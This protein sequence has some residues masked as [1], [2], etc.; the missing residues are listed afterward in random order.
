VATTK[1][2]ELGQ[3]GS[4]VNVHNENI[5]LD[6]NVHGQYAGFDSD[7]DIAIAGKTTSNL[8][9]GSNLYYTDAR[10]DARVAL[11]VDSAPS[12]LNTL[13]ELAAALGDDANFSTTVTN[14]IAAK[15]P[16]AGG[17]ITGNVT[18]GDNNKAIFGAEL[19]I[20]SDATHARIREY[21]SGQ[22]KIQ[23]D[24][25]QLLTSNGASTYLEGNASTSAVTLYHASNSPRL[26]TTSTGINVTGSGVPNITLTS[27]SGPYSYIESNTVGSLGFAADEGNTG[28]ATNINFRVDGN[29]IARLTGGAFVVNDGSRDIDFRVESDDNS[30]MLFVDAG[31]NEVGIGTNDP[32][33]PL[34]VQTSHSSTDV[35]AAN[36]NSTLSIGNSATGNGVYNAIKFAANQQD[37]YIMSFNNAQ[38]ADRRLGFFLGSTAGDAVA[39]ERLSIRGNGNVGIGTTSPAETL[40]VGT[41]NFRIDTDTNSTF[42][43]ADAGT[44]AIALY[45]GTGDELYMGANN[46]YSLRFKTD[47]NI[48]MD[49][50]GS[51]GIG[52]ASPEQNLHIKR[53]SGSDTGGQ[54]HIL[55]D[56]ADDSGP[57]YALRIGDTA[58][59]GDF[60]IDRRHGSTWSSSLSI[61]RATGNVG[62]NNTAPNATLAIANNNVSHTTLTVTP[63]GSGDQPVAE[64]ARGSGSHKG[65][66]LRIAGNNY[67]NGSNANSAFLEIAA[68]SYS[69]SGTNYIKAYDNTGTDFV[70]RGDGNVGIGTSSPNSMLEVTGLIRTNYSGVFN[71]TSWGGSGFIGS[72]PYGGPMFRSAHISASGSGGVNRDFL[73]LYTSGH[74]GQGVVLKINVI[75]TYYGAGIREYWVDFP[76]GASTPTITE[77]NH[78]GSEADLYID[79]HNATSLTS[80]GHSGQTVRKVTIRLRTGGAHRGGYATV[81]VVQNGPGRVWDSENSVS[82]VDTWANTNGSALHFTN[83]RVDNN[84]SLYPRRNGP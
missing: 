20:Y 79:Y 28:S 11:V 24:N 31:S 43:I 76:R 2:L 16:L 63:P 72:G 4:K 26:A 70:V 22:L 29:E 68:G 60:H 32:R 73:N 77:V 75:T 13:N 57:A 80:G 3:F 58:D 65:S 42:K 7:F 44:N 74:W 54:G 53:A 12:A 64:I 61:D 67:T 81:E 5:T 15:L 17:T 45:G 56:V 6:G 66:G 27:S 46:A 33:S 1:A 49:N 18:F 36:T 38:V 52:T 41:G 23:G 84:N 69:G 8:A 21:G 30:H 83:I 47:G 71:M 34:H 51:F 78:K 39:D 19:E 25:M 9:E 55:L 10:T 62:I 14:S 48:V 40:H 35:T 82:T 59:D 37:M 50:G